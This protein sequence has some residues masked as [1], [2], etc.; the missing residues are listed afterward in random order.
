MLK[1]S[2]YTLGL[3]ALI[4]SVPV[5]AKCDSITYTLTTSGCSGGCGTSPYGTITLTQSGNNVNV[6]ETLN[7]GYYLINTG[8][9]NANSLDFNLDKTATITN[10]TPNNLFSNGGS[11]SAGGTFGTFN[12][13][14]ECSGCKP[15]ASGVPNSDSQTLSFTVDGVTLT[16]F[17][18]STGGY[19]FASD[20]ADYNG[21][22]VVATGSV[23]ASGPGVPS[24]PVV[25]EPSSFL[26]AGTGL[27]VL[28]TVMTRR[29]TAEFAL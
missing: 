14:I 21:S 9:G 7:P 1:K 4:L 25:P 13:S 28:A 23:G 27:L 24:A 26:L 19:Y 16:D 17:T 2:L 11:D 20:I 3:S 6:V 29:R 5:A 15:G 18:Q 10:I 22:R 8:G 12:N